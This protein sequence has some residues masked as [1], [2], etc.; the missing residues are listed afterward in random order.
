MP[1]ICVANKV[2]M[3]PSRATKSFAFVEKR[4]EERGDFP[5]Y[6]VSACDGSNVV[7]IFKEAIEKGIKY[8]ESL[9]EEGTFVDQVLA[10]I[11][12]EEKQGGLFSDAPAL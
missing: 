5:F 7:S 10:F 6:F 11:K 3:D 1:V 8:K 9:A 4:R 2:D 12:E